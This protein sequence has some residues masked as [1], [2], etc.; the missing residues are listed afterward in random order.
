MSREAKKKQHVRI[1]SGLRDHCSELFTQMIGLNY[2]NA[3]AQPLLQL[4]LSLLQT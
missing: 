2:Y 1:Y 4:S 3:V